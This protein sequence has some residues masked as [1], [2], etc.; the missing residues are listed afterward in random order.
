MKFFH[1]DTAQRP[2]YTTQRGLLIA[3]KLFI[4]AIVYAP[5]LV[6]GYAVCTLVLGRGSDGLLW[7][8]L[9]VLFA[10]ILYYLLQLLKKGMISLKARGNY[11]WLP[12]FIFC[13]AFTCMLPLYIVYHPLNYLVIKLHGNK[14]VTDFLAVCFTLCLYYKYDFFNRRKN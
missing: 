2:L 4:N 7:F 8:G 5:L 10:I 9:T 3:L 14:T 11:W 12:L 1:Y 6:T 13:I